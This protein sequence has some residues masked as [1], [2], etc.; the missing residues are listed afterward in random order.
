MSMVYVRFRLDHPI[1]RET[2]R[3][4]PE[5]TL[6]WVRNV[7][8][9]DGSE[10]LF[11]ATVDDIDAFRQAVAADPTVEELSR[12]IPVDDRYLCQVELTESGTDTDLYPILLDTGSVVRDATVTADGWDCHFGFADATALSRFFETARERGID[13]EIDRVYEPRRSEE[14]DTGLTD[15]QREA[16]VTALE[17]GYFEVPRANG[18]ETVG[19]ELDISDTAVSERIRRGTRSLITNVVIEAIDTDDELSD[20]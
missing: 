2:M 15:A 13:Y 12:A 8:T 10:L 9:P 1:F 16:L 6:Q 3:Q 19:E 18:L 7:P 4:V 14:T 17:L 11:W 5:A 20:E